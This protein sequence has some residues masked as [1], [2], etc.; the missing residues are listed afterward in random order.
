MKRAN[1]PFSIPPHASAFIT[2]E[3]SGRAS[4]PDASSA[5]SAGTNT[6][7]QPSV[8]STSNR[9][10]TVILPTA[11][12]SV[13]LRTPASDQGNRNVF[14]DTTLVREVR[15]KVSKGHFVWKDVEL[16]LNAQPR[17]DFLIVSLYE[18]EAQRGADGRWSGITDMIMDAIG[19][20][21]MLAQKWPGNKSLIR[22][23]AGLKNHTWL[24]LA[25]AAQSGLQSLQIHDA[26]G[27][28]PLHIAVG[29]GTKKVVR[30]ILAFDDDAGSLRLR[31]TEKKNHIPLHIACAH[32]HGS[33]VALLLKI[34]GKEQ[35]L[36]ADKYNLLPIH[37]AVTSGTGDGVLQHLLAQCAAE[38][39]CA[40]TSSGTNA[41]M[42]AAITQSP[43]AVKRLLD[44]T[45]TLNGQLGVRDE[46]GCNA[47]DHARETGNA[48]VIA[49]LEA[50]MRGLPAGP[51][52][53]AGTASASTTTATHLQPAV[54]T[55]PPV[56]LTPNP[57]MPAPAV[58]LDFSDTEEDDSAL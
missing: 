30:A 10:G 18:I 42:L 38:Q 56:P 44:V 36:T 19:M 33:I 21:A 3:S 37:A 40:L 24:D 13:A 48:V 46:N 45:G 15:S 4:K 16:S 49:L 39:V 5:T 52:S 11:P 14:E 32:G 2:V 47:I 51:S 41:M 34:K 31:K 26:L 22:I 9:T 55:E 35:C 25:L 54:G 7:V 8:T 28:T 20:D 27:R 23:L 29:H 17:K 12:S 1:E 43:K 6:A 53:T 50:A 57:P 58:Q